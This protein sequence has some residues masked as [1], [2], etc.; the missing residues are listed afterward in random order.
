MQHVY[1][2]ADDISDTD[3]WGQSNIVDGGLGVCKVCGGMEGS[4]TT[5][6]P[7]ERIPYEKDQEVYAGKIDYREGRGWVPELNP[8]N[9][10]WKKAMEIRAALKGG[11]L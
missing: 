2:T 7:G 9:Q 5:D 10:T 3:S 1:Y 11:T 6:C 8:T 4:L